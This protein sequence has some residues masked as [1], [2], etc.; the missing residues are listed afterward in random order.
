MMSVLIIGIMFSVTTFII[1]SQNKKADKLVVETE[2]FH[3]MKELLQKNK[4]DFVSDKV[5]I[6]IRKEFQ[7]RPR[8]NSIGVRSLKSQKCSNIIPAL[9]EVG[10]YIEINKSGKSSK[11]FKFSQYAIAINRLV[12]IPIYLIVALLEVLYAGNN[13]FLKSQC[14]NGIIFCYFI[15]ASIIRLSIGLSNEVLASRY[16]YTFIK[17]KYNKEIINLSRKMYF[18]S[19]LS[20]LLICMLT[21]SVVLNIIY[22]VK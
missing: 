10:H 5:K 13:F 22:Y 20:Q 8:D 12:I 17:E 21:I 1:E 7:Y 4:V 9:H 11:M 19:F 2:C 14:I 16:A 15:F 6:D 3:V 18:T